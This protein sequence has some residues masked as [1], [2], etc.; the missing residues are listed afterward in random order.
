MVEKIWEGTIS[1]CALD[2]T[3]A[4][5]KEPK[6]ITFYMEVRGSSQIRCTDCS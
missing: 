6:T 2:L 4:A 1:V 3:R 5:S